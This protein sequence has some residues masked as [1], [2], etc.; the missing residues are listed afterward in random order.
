MIHLSHLLSELPPAGCTEDDTF[1]LWIFDGLAN[2]LIWWWDV[3]G[4]CYC[5]MGLSL[6]IWGTSLHMVFPPGFSTRGDIMVTMILLLG[7][8]VEG[9]GVAA[10]G[11]NP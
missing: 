8:W 1:L 2:Q 4:V 3:G 6:N 9:S 7:L 5:I 10:I 11:R